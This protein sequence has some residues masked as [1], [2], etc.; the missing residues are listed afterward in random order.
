MNTENDDLAFDIDPSDEPDWLTEQVRL[1][2]AEEGF[3][4]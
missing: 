4:R 2:D 1:L 3:D